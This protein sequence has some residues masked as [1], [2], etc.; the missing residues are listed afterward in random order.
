MKKVEIL[1]V[2]DSLTQALRLKF[3]L[4]QEGFHIY[5]VTDGIKAFELMNS[6]KPTLII[7]DVMMPNMDGYQFCTA[8]KENPRLKQIPI[9]LVT[10]LSD[11]TDVI[12]ALKA[13]A[14]NFLTKPFDEKAL[15]SRI[16][17]ILANLEIRKQQGVEM[18]VEVF[19][20][21]KR[22]FLN[23]S[24]IQMIDLLLS[25]Y[26]SAVQKNQELHN[27]NV[28]LRE[29]LENISILQKN[30]LQLLET[31]M[32][33]IFVID[34]DNLVKYANPSANKLFAP[35][36]STMIDKNFPVSLETIGNGEF[37]IKDSHG[38]PVFIDAM[39]M[40]T[41]WNGD[42]MTMIVMRNVTEAIHL[43][44]ELH[45]LSLTDDLTRLYNRRGFML[46][47]SKAVLQSKRQK[48]KIFVLFTDLDGLKHIN[49]TKGHQVGDEYLVAA[50]KLLVSSFREVDIIARMGGDEFAVLGIINEQC[51]PESL[52]DRLQFNIQNFNSKN[53]SDYP[54]SMSTGLA[55]YDPSI[56][57]SIE[58]VIDRADEE[59]YK[60]KR[61]RKQGRI[62]SE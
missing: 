26:E 55:T 9:I 32:D 18:G 35:A 29:A 8:L 59:M 25:T 61:A 37:E 36:D 12:L 48:Q 10:S 6:I 44:Q 45:Q 34:E 41:D 14:D 24:R 38:N 31:N 17:H 39:T 1:I 30:Y 54:L 16:R 58:H 46:F 3:V 5:H 2:E 56:T 57:D 13:G 4:E 15:I 21:G 22:Y 33:S 27:S 20:A 19:F 11:P 43:R 42:E 50:A 47:A 40:K 49:D 7:S 28:Q 53:F 23:S 52:I 60:Q 62:F 51:I